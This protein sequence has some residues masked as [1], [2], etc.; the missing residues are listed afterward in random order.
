MVVG[1]EEWRFGVMRLGCLRCSC[2]CAR[3]QVEN[4]L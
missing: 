2:V 4:K 3:V 1:Y